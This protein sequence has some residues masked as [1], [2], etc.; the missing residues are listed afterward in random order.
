[1]VKKHGNIYIEDVIPKG[2]YP[3]Q[4]TDNKAA[5]VMNLLAVHENMS[6]QTVY[7]IVKAMFDHRKDLIAVHK[8]A[9]NIKLENQKAAATPT[10]WHPGALKYY[11]EKGV[12][13]K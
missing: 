12:K 13:L 9:E 10:P 6:D 7:N 5:T 2:T 8:E 4:T 11:A 3:G 1:M